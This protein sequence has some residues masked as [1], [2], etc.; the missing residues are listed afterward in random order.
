MKSTRGETRIRNLLLS[1][2]APYRLGHTSSCTRIAT[3]R[4]LGQLEDIVEAKLKTK[5]QLLQIEGN[6]GEMW[7]VCIFARPSSGQQ[8]STFST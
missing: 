4:A 5:A 6:H 3:H 7:S 8:R 2:E 1:W